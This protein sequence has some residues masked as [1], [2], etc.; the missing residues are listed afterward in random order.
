MPLLM[1]RGIGDMIVKYGSTVVVRV[2][3]IRVASAYIGPTPSLTSQFLCGTI[4]PTTQT[5]YQSL[6]YARF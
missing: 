3:N 4:R 2:L 6:K 1:C 5:D